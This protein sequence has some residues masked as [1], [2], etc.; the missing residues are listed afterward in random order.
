[1]R[2]HLDRRT[3]LNRSPMCFMAEAEAARVQ[4]LEA[5]SEN[6]D[7]F[8]MKYLEGEN[9]T[10]E[11]IEAVIRQETLADRLVP[12]VC[13]AAFKNKGVQQLL[14]AIVKYLPSPLDIPAVHGLNPQG[15]EE[16][17]EVDAHAPSAA[18][19]FKIMTDPYVGQLTF[20]RVYSGVLHVGDHVLNTTKGVRERVGRL[21]RM[22]ANKREDVELVH[23]GDIAATVGLKRTLTG[24]TLAAEGAPIILEVDGLPGTGHFRGH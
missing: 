19:V 15:K 22:H 23:A 16:I 1:M 24:D 21:L 6:D 12:V 9:I 13:G 18:L 10:P 11:E 14:D 5:L 17:R 4:L 3:A 7:A 20:L 2:R 8:M